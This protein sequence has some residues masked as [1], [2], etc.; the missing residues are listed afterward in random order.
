MLYPESV[1]CNELRWEYGIPKWKAVALI[2]KY[3]ARGEYAVLCR[4]IEKRNAIVREE[5]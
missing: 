5:R 1:V 4:L 3:K 2:E